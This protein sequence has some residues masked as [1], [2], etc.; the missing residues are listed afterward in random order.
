MKKYLA[1][2]AVAL[3]GVSASAMAMD[4]P[5]MGM[6]M[7]MKMGMKMVDANGDGAVSKEE[8]MKHHEMMYDKMKKNKSGT[9]DLKDMSMMGSHDMNMMNKGN[10]KDGAKGMEGMEGMAK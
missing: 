8:F 10:S 1:V 3:I 6:K 7:D 2:I 5:K 9:V 4:D